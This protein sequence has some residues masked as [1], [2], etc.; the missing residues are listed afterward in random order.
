MGELRINL[1]EYRDSS[2]SQISDLSS[3]PGSPARINASHRIRLTRRHLDGMYTSIAPSLYGRRH[4]CGCLYFHLR[5]PD[6]MAL[7]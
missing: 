2:E 4:C 3:I 5:I 7:S 1:R 6:A